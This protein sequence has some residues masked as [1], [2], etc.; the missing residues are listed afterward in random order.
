MRTGPLEREADVSWVE[1]LAETPSQQ[2]L[3]DRRRQIDLVTPP[4]MPIQDNGQGVRLRGVP[5][6]PSRNV[7]NA[8]G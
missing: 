4:V 3:G 6:F 8:E 2:G 7:G 1:F 5:R